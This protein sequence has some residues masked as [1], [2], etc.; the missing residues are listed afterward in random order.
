MLDSANVQANYTKESNESQS[1][2]TQ[3]MFDKNVGEADMDELINMIA[4]LES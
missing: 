2:K 4:K 1:S 3:N